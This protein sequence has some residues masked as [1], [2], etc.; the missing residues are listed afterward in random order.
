MKKQYFSVSEHKHNGH[1]GLLFNSFRGEDGETTSQETLAKLF[2]PYSSEIDNLESGIWLNVE[3][4]PH[5]SLEG[6]KW[7]LRQHGYEGKQKGEKGKISW[8]TFPGL[9]PS[10]LV[11]KKVFF[12]MNSSG[13]PAFKFKGKKGFLSGLGAEWANFLFY[14]VNLKAG[15][16]VFILNNF[17]ESK[18]EVLEPG[19]SNSDIRNRW[20][21]DS[22]NAINEYNSH[23]RKMG[24][25][26]LILKDEKTQEVIKRIE[27]LW[28]SS[29][30]PKASYDGFL[31]KILYDFSHHK[32]GLCAEQIECFELFEKKKGLTFSAPEE[33]ETPMAEKTPVKET[34]TPRTFI[35]IPKVKN[36]VRSSYP[37]GDFFLF[38]IPNN[39]VERLSIRIDL[40]FHGINSKEQLNTF[41]EVALSSQQPPSSLVTPFFKFPIEASGKP[42]DG[43]PGWWTARKTSA[44]A[45]EKLLTNKGFVNKGTYHASLSSDELDPKMEIILKGIEI[46][47]AHPNIVG[48]IDMDFLL[49]LKKQI[50]GKKT[51]TERQINAVRNLMKKPS[52]FDVLKKENYLVKK[53]QNEGWIK[54]GFGSSWDLGF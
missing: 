49:S 54:G 2:E 4:L 25:S 40:I 53:A 6:L 42:Y 44:V 26:P 46:L 39:D 31:V 9:T 45:A 12:E 29:K 47:L 19:L 1:E 11:K 34:M 52:L 16:K 20:W 35:I 37:L 41:I 23:I 33:K 28:K 8:D 24:N 5:G 21:T 38:D 3:S 30:F 50:I 36:P 22:K 14:L 43:S 10:F 48:K 51:L 27:N 7:H 18:V 13:T 17:E 32:K 15:K